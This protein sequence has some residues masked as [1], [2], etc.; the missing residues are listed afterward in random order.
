MSL[1][2]IESI[3][4][5]N[6]KYWW[7]GWFPTSESCE[8]NEILYALKNQLEIT[9]KVSKETKWISVVK[10]NNRIAL[11]LIKNLGFKELKIQVPLAQSVKKK[12]QTSKNFTYFTN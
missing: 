3:F 10:K 6:R 12:F 7:G 4:L 8:I 1:D 2:I 11:N 5:D 9:S